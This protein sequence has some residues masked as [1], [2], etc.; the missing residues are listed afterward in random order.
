MNMNK[1]IQIVFL[2][3][4]ALNVVNGQERMQPK[5]IKA[6]ENYLHPSTRI[7]FPKIL[8]DD[9][10]REG[11]Y[12]FDKKNQN[13]GVT[14]EKNQNGEKTMISLF[15]YPAG[16]G[17]EGRLRQE[18]Q[19]SMQSVVATTKN[20]LH[21]IQ[22]ATQHK[23]EKYICNGFKAIFTN[24]QK[25][26]SQLTV[27]ESGTWFYKI[28]ITTNQ[29][30]TTT[31]SKLETEILQ[32]FDP[33]QLTDL[34][35]LEEKVSVYFAKTAFRDSVLLGSAMGSAY[36]KID[37]AM[38]NVSENERATGFPDLYLG[39]HVEAL[40]TFMEFQHRITAKKSEFTEKYL[41]EL[42]L[43][44]DADFLAEFVMEQYNLILMIPENQPDRYE[45]YL[46]WRTENNISINLNDK[47]YVLSFDMKK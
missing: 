24:E 14:Y 15:L 16:A 10:Q 40:K 26:L 47:F 2:F 41:K 5:K 9:Y 27:F 20:G 11:V 17:Y 28:R 35:R 42:Q 30:D 45:E 29:S 44:S 21:A 36:R 1:I 46:K 31:I 3:L 12:S 37:W 23:G 18:Y 19:K 25:D 4:A 39:L 8:F 38:D 43:I 13:I 22:V 6:K 32:K 7:D 33:T 34:K